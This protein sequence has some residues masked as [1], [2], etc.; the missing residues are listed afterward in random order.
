MKYITLLCNA[1]MSTSLLV[2][3]MKEEAKKSGAE[4]SIT[5]MAKDAFSGYT[6]PTDILLL[7]PQIRYMY[8]EIK[9]EYQ[10]K[11]IKVA[12]IH[13]ADYGMMNGKKV[14]EYALSL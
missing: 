7:G 10:P 5:A 11:G 13:M 1:G 3:K 8:E 12:V 2:N 6:G 14:L 4:V 9:E